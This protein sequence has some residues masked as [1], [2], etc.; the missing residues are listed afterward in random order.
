MTLVASLL[1]R[2]MSYVAD[3]TCFLAGDPV[4]YHVRVDRTMFYTS[5]LSTFSNEPSRDSQVSQSSQVHN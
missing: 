4:L 2:Q 3:H 5:V 1:V